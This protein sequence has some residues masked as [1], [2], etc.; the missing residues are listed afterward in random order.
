[1]DRFIINLNL[2][3]II[4]VL[5]FGSCLSVAPSSSNVTPMM[6][7]SRPEWVDGNKCSGITD[8][9]QSVCFVGQTP[10]PFEGRNGPPYAAASSAR[11]DAAV[12]YFQYLDRQVSYKLHQSFQS[13]GE[14]I[15]GTSGVNIQKELI[16][17]ISESTFKYFY[18][19]SVW[20]TSKAENSQGVR[21]F[22]YF[23]RCRIDK[24]L[25]EDSMNNV[26]TKYE[27]KAYESVPTRIVKFPEFPWPPPDP[28]SMVVLDRSLIF[29]NDTKN[30][31]I[32]DIND[33]INSALWK[34][35]YHEKSFFYVPGGYALVT[36]L[37][38]I[39]E[40]GTPK[41]GMQ[42][43][44]LKQKPL[45]SFDLPEY[46]KRLFFA[47]VGYYRLIVFVITPYPFHF[48]KP[49]ISEQEAKEWLHKGLNKLPKKTLKMKISQEYTCTALIYEFEKRD[50]K[51]I[52]NVV[53]P[54]RLDA[55]TH[56]NKSTF[57]AKLER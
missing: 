48:S 47:K 10:I 29:N 3:F 16:R 12:Q 45:R 30:A 9:E 18:C 57:L 32:K 20:W 26:L 28:S 54:G 31:T 34:A 44:A 33:R 11:S 27:L 15:E 38:Q 35:G 56:L 39:D 25:I 17:S 21:L 23:V 53:V 5:L 22:D 46:F 2:I 55:M 4:V 8:S 43:W 40:D 24:N 7:A 13:K 14:S 50:Q 51:P 37:E 42:R 6:P 36:R 52:E 19:D 49:K 41:E 1:M